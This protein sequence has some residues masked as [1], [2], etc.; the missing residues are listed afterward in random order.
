MEGL[1]DERAA[2]QKLNTRQLGYPRDLF[3]RVWGVQVLAL[4]HEAEMQ[5]LPIGACSEIQD[6]GGRSLFVV[7]ASTPGGPDIVPGTIEDTNPW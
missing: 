6:A 5:A 3:N 2:I 1:D 4:G 7:G